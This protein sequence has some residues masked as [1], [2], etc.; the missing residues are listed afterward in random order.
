VTYGKLQKIE[1]TVHS[2][3][4]KLLS[5]KASTGMLQK[6]NTCKRLSLCTSL[7]TMVKC[8]ILA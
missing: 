1:V 7:R 4:S 8:K 6:P 5:Y 2:T 3:I